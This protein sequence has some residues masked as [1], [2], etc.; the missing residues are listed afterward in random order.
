MSPHMTTAAFISKLQLALLTGAAADLARW[1]ATP[2]SEVHADLNPD[3]R[4]RVREGI[5]NAAENVVA[6]DTPRWAPAEDSSD[7]CRKRVQRAIEGLA[8]AGLVTQ[9]KSGRKTTHLRITDAG[10]D[11]ANYLKD[12]A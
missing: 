12:E 11:L 9:I 3:R 4:A 1:R 6:M 7:R 10:Q 5:Q 8:K 2:A